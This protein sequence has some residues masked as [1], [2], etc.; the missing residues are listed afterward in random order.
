MVI[1]CGRHCIGSFALR[2]R[3]ALA[4]VEHRPDRSATSMAC[5]TTVT[6]G[7]DQALDPAPRDATTSGGTEAYRPMTEPVSPYRVPTPS[8][9]SP[10]T[11]EAIYAAMTTTLSGDGHQLARQLHEDHTTTLSENVTE[12]LVAAYMRYSRTESLRNIYRQAAS[13]RQL[14][15]P[16]NIVLAQLLETLARIIRS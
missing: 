15:M 4:P 11:L 9:R 16:P 13:L 1:V 6:S 12:M 2:G 14:G 7:D 10:L 8:D 3:E 5:V